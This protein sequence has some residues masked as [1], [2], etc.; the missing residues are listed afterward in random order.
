VA[1]APLIL[2]VYATFGVGGTQVRSAAIANRFGAR[3]RHAVVAMDGNTACRER[4]DPSLDVTFPTVDI[5][6]GDTAGNVLRFRRVLQALRPQTLLTSNWGSIEW[7]MANMLPLLRPLVHHVHAEDG[8]GAEEHAG[9]FGRRVLVRRAMLRHC[10]VAVPSRLLLRVA[11]ETWRLDPGR[12]RYVPN[13]IDLGRFAAVDETSL[14][15]ESF[16]DSGPVV[17]TVAALRPE[18]NLGRLLRAFR[19]ATAD[20]PGR[21]VIVGDGPERAALE[22]LARDLGIAGRVRFTGHVAQQQLLYRGFDLFALS[23]DT[24]Q[25][26]LSVLEAMAAGLPVAATDVGDV[27]AMLADANAGLV[28]RLQDAALAGA[29]QVLLRQPELRRRLGLANRV[30]AARDYDE[31]VMFREWAG[32][33]DGTAASA[34]AAC[35]RGTG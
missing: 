9:Q 8:F 17:G 29:I 30:K 24:E 16:Q 14:P 23:S 7:A 6:K 26:P 27:R 34:D 35:R 10:T 18:K 21:L 22:A 33:I 3:W 11:T 13:G 15:D 19:L 2:H 5:R 32:L 4:L 28:T 31:E 20:V 12:L 1:E 25:M